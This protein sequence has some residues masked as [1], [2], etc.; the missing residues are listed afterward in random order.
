MMNAAAR[1]SGGGPTQ[2][3]NETAAL[4]R[5]MQLDSDLRR[6]ETERELIYYLANETRSVLGFRQA[7]VL[8]KTRDWRLKAVSSV[9]GFDPNAPINRQIQMLAAKIGKS[10]NAGD[11]QVLRLAGHKE[12]DALDAHMFPNAV[13]MPLKTRNGRIFA[14]ILVLHDQPWSPAALPL[15]ERVAEAGAHA[16]AALRGPVLDRRRWLRGRLVLPALLA[17]LLAAGFIQAPLTVLAPA[18]VGGQRT[19]AVSVPLDG[20]IDRVEVVPNQPVEKGAVL[21]RMEDTELRN[22]LL[23]AQRK[24]SVAQTRLAQLRNAAFSD[25]AAAR[26]LKIARAELQVAISEQELARERL[27]RIEVTAPKDGIAVFDDPR[28]LTGR[29]VNVGEQIMEIVSPGS[30]EFTIRLPVVDYITLR[31]G[32]DV[33]IFL[34]GNPLTPIKGHLTRSSY[35]AGAQPDGSFAYKMTARANDNADLDNVRIGAYGTAQLYGARHSIHYIVFR[36][37]LAWLRQKFGI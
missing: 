26:E 5:V 33:R 21:A 35:R 17:V 3:G 25:Q 34:D 12:L 20:V 24:V 15:V 19:A 2:S 23:I 1:P 9:T 6:I 32:A 4:L 22:A 16:W 13:W 36:R 11:V 31:E 37:P 28:I 8:R 18:E 27:D 29:P 14:A 30:L 10:E 7:F